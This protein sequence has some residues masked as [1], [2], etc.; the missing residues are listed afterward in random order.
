MSAD[1]ELTAMTA[2]EIVA[3]ITLGS[4]SAERYT[5]AC[6][7][8]I[9]AVEGEVQ[10]FVHLDRDHALSQARALDRHKAVG[11]RTGPLHGV[12]VGIK[13]IFDT[14]D[15]PTEC[16]S[17]ALA[18]R[19]PKTDG[20]V[21]AKLREAG[22]VIIGKTVTTELAYYH[23]GKTR[24]PRDLGR[25][26][27]GSSSGSAA[28]VAAGMVPLAIGAQTNGSMIRPAAF[29]GVFAIKASHGMVS[30]AGMMTASRVL[31]QPGVFARSIDDLALVMDVIAGQDA[32]D[33]D[34]RPYAAPDFRAVASEQPPIPPRFAFVRTPVWDK[35]DADT[36]A[37][38]ENL[39]KE[40][41]AQELE[42]PPGHR[43]AWDAHRAIMAA[44]MA[45]NLGAIMDQG[46]EFSQA[47]RDLIAE[48]RTIAAT[49]YLAA[50]R[51]ARRYAGS[52]SEIF[53]QRADA[54]ITPSARGVAP[55]GL[56]ATGDPV[57]CTFWTLTGLPALNLPLLADD[58]GLPL[59]VQLIGAPGRDA[60][61]LRSANWLLAN[62]GD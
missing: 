30:R 39:A 9:D 47:F 57:F 36:Q 46:G 23:P 35:A 22:A 20:A 7:D 19:R 61:L 16:G 43:A 8:R 59:G 37:A 44:D 55:K 18:G 2:S 49:Q 53:E 32:S 1:A 24:N 14:A 6:L 45:D 28:A 31:D 29:C 12:P 25:T 48:G 54:I 33:P 60:R 5:T 42:L 13:D 15:F 4:I 3:D 27:G 41:G 40:I 56:Q 52:M 38:L 50:V 34:T 11:G 17:P 51:D 21:V 10:A 62:L 58:E 26:P